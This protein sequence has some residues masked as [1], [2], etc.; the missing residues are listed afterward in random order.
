MQSIACEKNYGRKIYFFAK[1][2]SNKSN[3]QKKQ[4]QKEFVNQHKVWCG[5]NIEF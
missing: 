3:K 4:T 2:N 1:K 5:V